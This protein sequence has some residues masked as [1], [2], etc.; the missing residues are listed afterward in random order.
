MGCDRTPGSF[1]VTEPFGVSWYFNKL[2][3][4]YG[5]L[6][7][8][9]LMIHLWA[10]PLLRA[11]AEVVIG[12]DSVL[13]RATEVSKATALEAML[14][15]IDGDDRR[16]TGDPEDGKGGGTFVICVG[17]FIKRDEDVFTTVQ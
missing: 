15:R 10:G 17:D 11:P 9:D 2:Q 8:K 1:Y 3:G 4:D 5:A 7:S 14:T 16:F 13:V 6:Q 12:S